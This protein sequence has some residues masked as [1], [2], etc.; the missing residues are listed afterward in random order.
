LNNDVLNKIGLL[1][2]IVLKTVLK[3][4]KNPCKNLRI[5]S[6]F[7]GTMA[8]VYISD[9]GMTKFGRREESLQTLMYEAYSHAITSQEPEFDAVFIGSMNPDE[10][11][12]DSNF[13]T[14]IVDHL[15]LYQT[16]SVRIDNAPASGSAAFEQAY[17]SIA[18]GHYNKVLVLAGEKMSTYPTVITTSIISKLIDKYERSTGA[19][20]PALA[21]LVTRRY[22]H[23]YGLSREELALAAVKNHYNGTFNPY[24]QFQKEITVEDI[25]KSKMIADPLHLFDCASIADGACAAILSSNK[26]DVKVSGIG[27]ATDFLSLQYRDSLTSFNATKV[28]AKRAYERANKTPKDIDVAEVHDAFTILEIVN[29]EDLG[30]FKPGQGIAALIEGKTGL[31]GDLPINPSGGLEA[32]G[33]PVGATGLA[34]ICEIVWQLRGE[35]G[36]RQVSAKIGLC[37]NIGG[38][39]NNNIVTILEV[40]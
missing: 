18:S 1:I 30:F 14:L 15:G 40:S 4:Y 21:A 24:A 6:A 16:P 13:A 20:M 3:P 22:M 32:R 19:T 37:H 12:G 34:Q 27:H 31:N 2:F 7:K 33:H 38:F 29:P 11:V 17:F 25:L 28:A 5:V 39:V 10:F 36:K 8:N 23:D 9:V 26:T 35:A